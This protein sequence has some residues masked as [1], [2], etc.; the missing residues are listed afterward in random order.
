M[1]QERGDGEGKRGWGRREGGRE[2]EREKE[3]DNLSMERTG[4]WSGWNKVFVHSL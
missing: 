4:A 3:T 1:G 2:V